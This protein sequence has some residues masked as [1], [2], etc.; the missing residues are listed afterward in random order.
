MTQSK[1]TIQRISQARVNLEPVLMRAVAKAAVA[2]GLTT[3]TYIRNLLLR[4]MVKTGK[5]TN[6]D[7]LALA[8]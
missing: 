8:S 3:S 1:M 7:L 6:D 5:I 4:E 2:E